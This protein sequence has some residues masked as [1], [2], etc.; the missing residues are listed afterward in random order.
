MARS[1]LLICVNKN[2]KFY[3]FIN[4]LVSNWRDTQ[5]IKVDSEIKIAELLQKADLYR[6]F[7]DIYTT[8]TCALWSRS[9]NHSSKSE[10]LSFVKNILL[11]MSFFD[12]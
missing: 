5:S 1:A 8:Q 9:A 3:Y 12:Q 11:F 6:F 10:I 2:I 4:Y 7:Y